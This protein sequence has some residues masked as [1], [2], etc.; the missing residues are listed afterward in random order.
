M[1]GEKSGG[2]RPF[3]PLRPPP[4]AEHSGL[5][6]WC[7]SLPARAGNTVVTVVTVMTQ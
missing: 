2:R 7:V 1:A 5:Y 6:A 3:Q 4:A